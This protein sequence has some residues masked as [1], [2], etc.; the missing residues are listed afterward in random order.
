[1][2]ERCPVRHHCGRNRGRRPAWR[3]EHLGGLSQERVECAVERARL[4]GMVERPG[5]ERIPDEV[6]DQLLAGAR[7]E[8]EI[9]GPGGLGAT[10]RLDARRRG[11][12]RARVRGTGEITTSTIGRLR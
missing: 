10:K 9:A 5:G 6:I 1:M 8:E 4:R 11:R 12:E 3:G 2:S 7:T